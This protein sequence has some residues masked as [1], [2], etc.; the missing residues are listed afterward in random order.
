MC[1]GIPY[2]VN[3]I[4]NTNIEELIRQLSNLNIDDLL[5]GENDEGV[6]YVLV[7]GELNNYYI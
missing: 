2:P 6:E 7:S 5:H 4:E 3:P 1:S